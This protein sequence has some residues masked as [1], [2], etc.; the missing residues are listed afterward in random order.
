MTS[1]HFIRDNT[2]TI[3]KKTKQ[4]TTH[5][6][7]PT[8]KSTTPMC[9]TTSLSKKYMTSKNSQ[10]PA[11]PFR[12]PVVSQ[13]VMR[14]GYGYAIHSLKLT[15]SSPLKIGHPKGNASS[16]HWFSGKDIRE[17]TKITQQDLGRT[18]KGCQL[19][20]GC[21]SYINKTLLHYQLIPQM[22]CG[23]QPIVFS[24]QLLVLGGVIPKFL[25]KSWDI[26]NDAVFQVKSPK[27]FS[28][29]G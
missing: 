16:N 15:A 2:A 9:H 10:R 3:P 27:D 11:G 26:S 12:D 29:W 24:G 7:Q 8:K 4:H 19:L 6:K 17:A 25:P 13:G 22:T 5:Q 14:T 20:V 28:G 1:W 21:M 18:I 23:H